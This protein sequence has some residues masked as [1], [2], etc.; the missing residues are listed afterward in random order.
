MP[1]GSGSPGPLDV[2]NPPSERKQS[3]TLD[4]SDNPSYNSYSSQ[5]PACGL[6]QA[7]CDLRMRI[8]F[9]FIRSGVIRFWNQITAGFDGTVIPQV[10]RIGQ[11]RHAR[12]FKTN[13]I[14]LGAPT[15]GNEDTQ[16]EH[17]QWLGILVWVVR[18]SYT[19]NWK[20]AFQVRLP[21]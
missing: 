6:R 16:R 4:P 21:G 3:Q 12:R 1:I 18:N 20:A 13:G 7:I 17:P 11:V 8:Q 10:R 15:R 19:E 9:C 14:G 5:R 2:N